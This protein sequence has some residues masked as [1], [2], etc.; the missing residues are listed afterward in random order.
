MKVALIARKTLFTVE[1]GDTVQIRQTA[2]HLCA[3]G[4]VADIRLTNEVIA[5]D[6][7]DLLHFFNIIRPADIHHHIRKSGKPFA[8]SPILIDYNEF[9]QTYRIGPSAILL[10]H[11]PSGLTEYAKTIGRFI[12]GRD[13]IASL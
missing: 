3:L 13:G 5:Y 4:I 9:D 2:R 11:L 7:Y 6:Q 10:K 8:V 12:A 1:G